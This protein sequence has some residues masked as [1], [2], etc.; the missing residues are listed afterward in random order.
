MSTTVITGLVD[1]PEGGPEGLGERL[2]KKTTHP[3]K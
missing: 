2:E 3:Q 1:R